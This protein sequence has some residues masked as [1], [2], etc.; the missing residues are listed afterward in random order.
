VD[1]RGR[2]AMAGM[3]GS[4]SVD[5]LSAG[6]KRGGLI[7]SVFFQLNFSLITLNDIFVHIH[8]AV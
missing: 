2:R 8:L 7:G 6:H 5:L 3:G 4:V 1:A